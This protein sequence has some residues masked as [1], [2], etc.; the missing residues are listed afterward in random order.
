MTAALAAQLVVGLA[1]TAAG[2]LVARVAPRP[3]AATALVG[4]LLLAAAT[5]TAVGAPGWGDRLWAVAVF[6]AL[7][8]ALLLHPDGAAPGPGGRVVLGV[9][10]AT[11][12]LALVD[13]AGFRT[14]QV[15]P[16]V[17]A[18]L[19][20]AGIWW[21]HEHAGDRER[22]ALLWLLLGLGVTTLVALP[23]EFLL[24]AGTTPGGV[25]DA[26]VP[27]PVGR[28]PAHDVAV[29]LSWLAVPAAL[30]VGARSPE[31]GD[32]RALIVRAVVLAVTALTFV[33]VFVGTA[34][35][36]DLAGGEA[37]V[38]V[39]AV[40]GA[41][42][43]AGFGPLA[44]LLRGAVDRMLFG[45]RDP[46]I[47]AAS[48]VGEQLA[49]DPVPALRALRSALGVPYAALE[50]GGEVV[51]ASGTPPAAL[52]RLSLRVGERSA[53]ELVVG[54]RPGTSALDAADETTLAIVAP[55]LAQ[56]V[57]ARDLAR[58]L[59]D[60]RAEMIT[61]VEDERRRLRRDL[62]DGLGPT[63]TGVA[64]AADAARNVLGADPDRAAELVAG[65]RRDVAD[66]IAEIRRL[67]EGLRPPAVDELGLVGAL[68]QQ[69]TRMHTADGRPL[70]VRVDVP[71]P[72]P[73]LPAAVEVAAY[74][75]VVEALTN[76][77]RHARTRDAAVALE[78]D[79]DRLRIAVR[80]GGTTT[81]EWVPG[82]GLTSMRERAEQLGGTF[83]AGGGCVEVVLPL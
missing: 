15:V 26:V 65:L 70:A 9:A 44:A 6:V 16:V 80:D 79:G 35:A 55:A 46:P 38:P 72:L 41:A 23:L 34:S 2:L 39:L 49:D 50:R 57:L 45:D 30:V 25:R 24:G 19:V 4:V 81:A 74:R 22:R 83:R 62:H 14:T 28:G 31:R 75:I 78:P 47:A 52:R 3:A 77:A 1:F 37:S 54:L 32:V 73:V 66:A 8:V 10:V 20:L 5:A 27:D 11:G 7:P 71:V 76:V 68:S 36:I 17:L 43:A 18:V 61:A 53:G 82:V 12:S 58:Q 59:Q 63:L 56:T 48:R 21:R 13:P 40:L 51:A 60:S 42:C 69:A 29:P 67:V 33:A 64:F